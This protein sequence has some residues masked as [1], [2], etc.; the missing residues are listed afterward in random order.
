VKHAA[1]VDDNLCSEL[2]EIAQETNKGWNSVKG[3]TMCTYDFY[4]GIVH[5]YLF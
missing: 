1:Y 3:K 2:L 4:E 5:V